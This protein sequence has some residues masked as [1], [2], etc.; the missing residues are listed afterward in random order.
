MDRQKGFSF[1]ELMIVI[2][3][4]GIMASAVTINLFQSSESYRVDTTKEKIIIYLRATRSEAIARNARVGLLIN[5]DGSYTIA[6]LD[7]AGTVTAVIKDYPPDNSTTLPLT[8]INLNLVNGNRVDFDSRGRIT[9]LTNPSGA[10]RINGR[11][12]NLQI[13]LFEATGR[14]QR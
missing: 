6:R 14:I 8:Y 12:R 5:N 2:L 10:I 1:L 4:M 3:I 7:S 9:N 11:T 13:N